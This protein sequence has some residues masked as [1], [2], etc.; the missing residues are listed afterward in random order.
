MKRKQTLLQQ[1]TFKH[2]GKEMSYL[3]QNHHT[4][5]RWS[6]GDMKEVTMCPE[7]Q[8]EHP[9]PQAQMSSR[10]SACLPGTW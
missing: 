9:R 5:D 8:T 1:Q 4:Q 2:K 10:C 3:V 7:T 6:E